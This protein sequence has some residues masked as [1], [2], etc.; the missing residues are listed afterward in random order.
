MQSPQGLEKLQ[1]I[2]KP[3]RRKTPGF[4]ARGETNPEDEKLRTVFQDFWRV[5]LG[6]VLSMVVFVCGLV[7]SY[8]HLEA[9][10]NDSVRHAADTTLHIPFD[11]HY[12]LFVARTEYLAKNH[13]RDVE[14]ADIK[15]LLREVK[16]GQ[17]RLYEAIARNGAVQR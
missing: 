17:D 6:N 1:A 8:A 9:K 5:T 14:L 7:Y 15:V 12:E 3:R 10:V 2:L 16:A 4:P 11:K 13:S